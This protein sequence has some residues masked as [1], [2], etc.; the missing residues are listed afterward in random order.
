[1]LTATN[2]P[3]WAVKVKAI[4]DAN[5]VWETVEPMTL[6]EEPDSKKK[7]QALAFL[8]Q[9]IPK[10]MVLQMAS[11]AD[12]KQVW[13][14][15]KTRF[16]GVDRV[17]TARLATLKRE[18]ES[19]RMKEGE[20][21]LCSL[22]SKNLNTKN[23]RLL[24]LEKAKVIKVSRIHNEKLV[25]TLLKGHSILSL[26]GSLSGDCD[27]EK[28]GKWSCIYAV[29]SQEYQMVCTRLDI[30]SADVG[31]L[32]KFDRGL[33]TDVQVFVDF[34]YAMAA[35][36]TLTGA[37]KKEIWLKGLLAESGYELS[38]VAGIATGALVKGGSRSEV[39][40]QVE[41]SQQQKFLV[42]RFFD[43]KEQQGIDRLNIEKLDGN[44]VQ[45]DGGSKQVGFK[46]LGPGVETGVH[47]VHDEKCAWF[48]VELQGA[49][50]DREAEV[51]QVS[52][53]DTAVAQRWLED[54]QHEKKT[55]TNCLRSTQQCTKSGVAKHL[56]VAGLQQQNGL[57]KETNVTLLAKVVLY[58]N[59]GFNESGEY[60][61]TFIGSG[62][63]TGS[64][65]VLQGDEFEV[66]P[67]DGHTFE[68]EPH[69]NVDHV[70]G[71]QEVQTQ[72]LI[73]YHP[74][75][76]REQHSVWELFS[77][78]KTV[79]R[80]A[81]VSCAVEKIYANESLT[82][83]MILLVVRCVCTQQRWKENS[84]KTV[85]HV[86]VLLGVT[87]AEI[88]VTKGLLV[89]AKKNILGLE[90]IRG[91]EVFNTAKGVKARNS[92]IK[93]VHTYVEGALHSVLEGSLSGDCD[94]EKNGKWS[95]IYAVGSQE[96]QMVCT[97]L[98]IAS[99]DVGML[100]KFDRGLQTDAWKKEIWLK[101]LL[102]ESGYELS[103][104]AGIA[105]GAL[106]KGGSRSEVLAQVKGAAYRVIESYSVDDFE[107]KLTGLT[108]KA[109]S[110]GFDLEEQCFELDTMPFDE[111]VGRLK[112]YE[113]RIKGVEK[114][115]GIQGGLLLASHEKTHGCKHCGG[116]SSNRDDFGR[117]RGRGR[118]SMRGRDGNERVWD[119][120]HVKCYKCG[121]YGHIGFGCRVRDGVFLVAV[122]WLGR[123]VID[124]I[125]F[126][127]I[128]SFTINAERNHDQFVDSLNYHSIENP[129]ILFEYLILHKTQAEHLEGNSL[130]DCSLSDLELLK[131][132]YT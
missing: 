96:Y 86:M 71:S 17:R 117:G 40:A 92:T 51:F 110:L 130:S 73:Y 35:Y 67:Q 21:T 79:M 42:L 128:F 85:R 70:V 13:D 107:M 69:G 109:R 95:C 48:E 16:L 28:N 76:D 88:L 84:V 75:R 58:R 122:V 25:Q 38:L 32:D 77:I 97:R 31:M 52:N 55:N 131:D 119:K 62:V 99:A 72:D 11:Y 68:V 129:A 78:E 126:G 20:N 24:G 30:A 57:V 19:L 118:R 61:K 22:T 74:A 83:Q 65:Q 120:S 104:V 59:M 91:L 47:G 53:D 132:S 9:A 114:E 93:L 63:G 46:Q 10:E 37:W 33:Q 106:V 66:E 100:D 1:M 15:L 36:M 123:R 90:I 81:F 115:D 45:K 112:A 5:G 54:K 44:I 108:S 39:P 7:K 64:M 113:E 87:L 121:D 29:G 56:G 98:D 4:M 41:G 82:S 105:T 94:V 103:L 111:T 27:V 127:Q 26:E 23:F 50:G 49:Q 102:A 2:Y 124:S 80:F 12:P 8:F 89:K 6:G 116:E 43:V 125:G 14:G 101:G 3:V 34:D 18:L 60:K